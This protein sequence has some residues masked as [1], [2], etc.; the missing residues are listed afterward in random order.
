MSFDPKQPRVPAGQPGAGEWVGENAKR[1]TGDDVK[2]L[3]PNWSNLPDALLPTSQVAC[4]DWV[5]GK[6][7]AINNALRSGDENDWTSGSQQRTIR[8]LDRAFDYGAQSLT[9]DTVVY[10][11]MDKDAIGELK[12]GDTFTDRGFNSTS[13][14]KEAAEIFTRMEDDEGDETSGY[15][16]HILLPKGTKVI[17]PEVSSKNL[18]KKAKALLK[19]QS[20]QGGE[21]E[22]L[23]RRG[24]TYRVIK[25]QGRVI[26]LTVIK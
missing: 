7:L 3:E 8:G 15:L 21:Q 20:L 25:R 9:E 17:S 14:D 1:L 2:K 26:Y 18:T 16:A 22:V 12:E 23:L 4:S 5:S 24:T 13:I 10:R 19:G 11:G 6:Y